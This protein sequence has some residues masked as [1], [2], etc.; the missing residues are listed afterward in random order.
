M[1][2]SAQLIAVIEDETP[3][4]RFLHASLTVEGF[5]VLEATNAKEGM[6][7]ITQ[8]LPA[9]VLLDLGLTV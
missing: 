5:R 9:L 7:L 3:I 1:S 4:R 8:Q 6:R 2:S